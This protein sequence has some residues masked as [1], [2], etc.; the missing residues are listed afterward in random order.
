MGAVG[1]LVAAVALPAYTG[2]APANATATLQQVASDNAQSLVVASEI[3]SAELERTAY[4]A[5]SEKEVEK[6]KAQRAA[7][8]RYA[9]TASVRTM[10]DKSDYP[11]TSPGSGEVRYPLPKDSY[12]VSRTVGGAHRGADMVATSGTPI[13]AAAAGVVSVSSESYYGYGVA[14]KIESVIGGKKVSTLYAHMI[15]GSRQV[16]AGDTVEA[17][18][19]IGRVGNTGA[20]RGAHLHFEVKVSGALAEPIAWLKANAG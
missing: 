11:I 18:Q 3:G 2:S 17:G 14:I 6:I 5:T 9:Q 16:K 15:R 19:R 13:Y 1:T 7:A 10:L 8:S 12:K 20:S 4:L